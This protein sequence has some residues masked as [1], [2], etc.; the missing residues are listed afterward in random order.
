MLILLTIELVIVK[1]I[2]ATMVSPLRVMTA[3]LMERKEG[4]IRMGT[5][6]ASCVK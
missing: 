6:M 3:S 2:V 4:I 5:K 1:P